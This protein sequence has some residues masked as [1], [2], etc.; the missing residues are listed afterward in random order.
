MKD[1]LNRELHDYDLVIGMI[2]SR[3]SDGMRF[4]VW[5]DNSV[6]WENGIRSNV[7]NVYLVENPNE[8]ETALKNKII[9][10]IE[11]H[12]K[13]KE[14]KLEYIKSKELKIGNIYETAS[15]LKYAY[16]GKGNLNIISD[17]EE[18]SS[19]GY[20][21]LY[22]PNDITLLKSMSYDKYISLVN[23]FSCLKSKKKFIEDTEKS[24]E[25]IDNPCIITATYEN[26][27]GRKVFT[28]V[29]ITLEEV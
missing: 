6:V 3:Y 16:L 2:I 21:Y 14:V 22:V 9:E 17:G 26:L 20:L 8:Q 7:R 13:A 12:E 18:T 11:E 25:I 28:K 19:G 15:G 10:K 23:V 27:W 29:S 24:I 1:I 5:K 4:G